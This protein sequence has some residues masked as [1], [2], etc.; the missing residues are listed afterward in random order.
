MTTIRAATDGDW[1]AISALLTQH[2]LPLAGAR[3]HLRHFLV[4]EHVSGVAGAGGLEVHGSAA[5]LRSLVVATR[6]E[7]LGTRL[8]EALLDQARRLGV[9]DVVLLTT[10]AAGFFPRFGFLPIER[11]EV[12]PAL[13]SSRE[14][15]GACPSS[16]QVMRVRLVATS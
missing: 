1:I 5:L 4:A 9:S 13:L 15:Q 12:P 8:V 16:A 7:G 2:G 10:T 3:E 14:F 11:A 6:G